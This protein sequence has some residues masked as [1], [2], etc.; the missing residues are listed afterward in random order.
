VLDACGDRTWCGQTATCAPTPAKHQRSGTPSASGAAGLGFGRDERADRPEQEAGRIRP[1]AREGA[2]GAQFNFADIPVFP[3]ARVIGV[4]ALPPFPTARP[5]TQLR[6]GAIDGP[7][8]VEADKVADRVMHT[9]T[10]STAPRPPS[11]SRQYGTC[12][13]EGKLKKAPAGWQAAVGEAPAI[14]HEMLRSLGQPLDAPIR[15]NF[16]PQFGQ[17]FSSVRVHTDASAAQ[18]CCATNRMRTARQ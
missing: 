17:D 11:I 4:Q 14:V 9:P 5:Q 15:A 7:L 13:E 16:E 10:G 1:L 18:S 12:D 6:V 2:V 8:E 3:S